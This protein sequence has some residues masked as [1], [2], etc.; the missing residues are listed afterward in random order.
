VS[1]RL[2]LALVTLA[3]AAAGTGAFFAG[4]WAAPPADR[5]ATV[6]DDP[7]DVA[8]L[9]LT[10]AAD[11]RRIAFGELAATADWTLVFFGFVDCPDVCPLTMARLA[12]TYRDLGEPAN[13]QVAMITVDPDRDVGERLAGYVRAFHPDFVGLGGSSQDVAEAAGRFFVGFS[14]A[15]PDIVHTQAV[16]L[17]DRNGRLRAVYGSG[18]IAGIAD[19]LVDLLAGDRL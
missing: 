12:E 1:P 16:G 6:L 19:D 15:G 7:Q 14:G 2:R 9:E 13:L 17:V 11:G 5:V 8:D 3:L 4:R 18:K 10:V